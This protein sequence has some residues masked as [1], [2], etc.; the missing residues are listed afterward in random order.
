M[1]SVVRTEL[2]V[3]NAKNFV[4][5]LDNNP[6][7][8]R[9]L[10]VGIAK[11]TSWADDAAPPTPSNNYDDMEAFWTDMFAMQLIDFTSVKL[12]VPRKNWTS[13]TEYF[14]FDQASTSAYNIDFYV[15]NSANEVFQCVGVPGGAVVSTNEP[16]GH[17]SGVDQVLAD[18]YTWK[19]LYTISLTDSNEMNSDNWMVVNWDDTDVI[20]DQY[21]FGVPAAYSVLGAK[22]VMVRDEL[23]DQV[24]GGMTVGT[25]YRQV[26]LILDPLLTGGAPLTATV[27]NTIANLESLSGELIYLENRVPVN[28]VNGQSEIIKLV[29]EV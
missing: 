25:S 5:V 8:T 28:R 29:F 14:V 24:S 27:E 20:S 6:T 13:G 12:V 19:Y 16:S 3:M 7:L 22:Y 26:G 1:P 9:R 23:I 2:E 17:N 11:N 4:D 18:G 10:Y 15:L 21:N